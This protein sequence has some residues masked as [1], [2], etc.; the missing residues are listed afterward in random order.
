MLSNAVES[1][2]LLS[3]SSHRTGGRLASLS[4][5]RNSLLLNRQIRQKGT[6]SGDPIAV[7]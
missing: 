1:A 6:G 5:H 4:V 3:T 7:D 2:N